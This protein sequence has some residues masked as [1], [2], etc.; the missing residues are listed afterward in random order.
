VLVLFFSPW[1]TWRLAA[2]FGHL[3]YAWVA[4][5]AHYHVPP[6]WT[7]GRPAVIIAPQASLIAMSPLDSDNGFNMCIGE[8]SQFGCES[9]G[10]F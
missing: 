4:V 2:D 5:M 10:R 6:A 9:D 8:P 1:R 3:A 7:A